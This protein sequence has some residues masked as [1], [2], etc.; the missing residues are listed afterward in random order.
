MRTPGRSPFVNSTPPSSSALCS[1][2]MVDCLA[3]DPFSIRVT[4][5][6]VT[7]ALSAS[8]R[9]PHRKAARAILS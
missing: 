6:A 3:S 2:F 9:T 7:P 4:V 1:A 5:L 8:S